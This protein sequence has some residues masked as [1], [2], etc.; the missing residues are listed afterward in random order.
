MDKATLNDDLVRRAYVAYFRA[1][2]STAQQPSNSLSGVETYSKRQ[3]VVL[4]NSYHVLE[5]Y[6][7]LNNGILK[8]IKA[9][10]PKELRGD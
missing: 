7:V 6:R 10:W 9:R 4:R 5:V 2:G 3:Y 8:R 1:N